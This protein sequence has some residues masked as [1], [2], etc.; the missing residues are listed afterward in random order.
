MRLVIAVLAVLL[1]LTGCSAKEAISA[2]SADKI[3]VATPQMVALK[4]KAGVAPCPAAQTTNGGLPG[5]TL[6][7]LGGG[8]DV[9]LSTLKGPLVLNFFANGC[10]PCRKEMP[11]LEKFY[12]DHGRQVPV[13]GVDYLDTYPGVAL[14][15]AI[16]RGVRYPML[17]DP[18]GGLQGT[19]LSVKGFPWFFFLSADGTLT[20]ETGGKTSE[21]QVT[22]MVEKHLGLNL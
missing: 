10:A 7:C 8:R 1:V 22:A 9:D 21:A 17:A 16:Q 4:H 3:P 6:R 11:A 5:H 14:Q 2:P 13:I 18:L 20:S 19:A 12:R 15:E